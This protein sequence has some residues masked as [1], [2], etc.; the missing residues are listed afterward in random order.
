LL[1]LA[2]EA[3]LTRRTD[4]RLKVVI[5]NAEAL[6]TVARDV[7]GRAFGCPARETYGNAELV[8]AASECGAGRLHLW[9][10]VGWTEVHDSDGGPGA[11]GAVG[12]LIGTSLINP[13]MPLIRFRIGDVGR[14]AADDATCACGRTLPRLDSIVGR[15]TDV[16]FT[17]DGRRV[18]YLGAVFYGLPIRQGQV[19]QEALDRIRIRYAP[20]PDFVDSTRTVLTER[21]RERMGNVNVVLEAVDELPRA[22]SGK[23]RGVICCIPPEERAAVLRASRAVMPCA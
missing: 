19:V 4:V 2:Q 12:E 17:R 21:I 13:D 11:A 9:P 14:L 5:T 22:G 8:T 15:S 3:L 7:I 20:A 10:E 23:L 16:L 6:T 18:W 1:P